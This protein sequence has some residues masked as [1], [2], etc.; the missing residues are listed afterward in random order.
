MAS[1]GQS[2]V[3]STQPRSHYSKDQEQVLIEAVCDVD[4]LQTE[5]KNTF[6]YSGLNA[7]YTGAGAFVVLCWCLISIPLGC[8]CAKR[9][10]N[11]WLLHLTSSHIYY[12]RKHYCCLC[13]TANTDIEVNLSDVNKAYVQ[14]ANVDTGCCSSQQLPTTVVVE[15]KPGRRVDLLPNRCLTESC[16]GCLSESDREATVVK[17]SFTH[18]VNAEDFVNA[19]KQ[20][21]GASASAEANF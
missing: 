2:G 21:V 18:C 1:P 15:L 14:M 13:K 19:V 20:Q 6:F 11:S 16:L 3:I 9:V 7:T 10:A 12:A 4:N 8:Y 5:I 17:L